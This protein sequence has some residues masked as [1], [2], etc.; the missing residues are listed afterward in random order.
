TLT[1][2]VTTLLALGLVGTA[3][4]TTV[5]LSNEWWTLGSIVS[6]TNANLC[7]LDGTTYVLREALDGSSVSHLRVKWD[8]VNVPAGTVSL[9]FHGIRPGNSDGDNFQ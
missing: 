1:I 6:G 4:A 9:H 8:F 7:A 2:L 5:C 3:S